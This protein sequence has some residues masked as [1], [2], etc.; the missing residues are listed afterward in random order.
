MRELETDMITCEENGT[1]WEEFAR[2][3][4]L[5]FR[6]L[7]CYI[8]FIVCVSV[9]RAFRNVVVDV[10]F[11]TKLNLLLLFLWFRVLDR[12]ISRNLP[13]IIFMLLLLVHSKIWLDYIGQALSCVETLW[14]SLEPKSSFS[15]SSSLW[16][17]SSWF[18]SR[19][20]S[21][22]KTVGKDS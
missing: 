22:I 10:L 16:S 9:L 18:I 5:N 20:L 11:G 19:D 6:L 14:S 15:L 7:P 3:C 8:G 4:L 21:V 13:I 17:L 12:S 2:A 1:S